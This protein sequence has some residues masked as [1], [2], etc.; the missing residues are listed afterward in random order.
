MLASTTCG[1]VLFVGVTW[2]SQCEIRGVHV[3]PGMLFE[4]KLWGAVARHADGW[5]YAGTFVNTWTSARIVPGNMLC[6]ELMHES[7]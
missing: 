5:G 2:P 3:Q 7:A 4:H 1:Y 6:V